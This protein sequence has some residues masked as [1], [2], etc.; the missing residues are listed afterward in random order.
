ML[1]VILLSIALAAGVSAAWLVQAVQPTEAN[2][3]SDT[4]KAAMQTV[5]VLVAATDLPA[6]TVLQADDMRWQ[7]WPAE[8]ANDAFIRYSARPT[9]PTEIAGTTL[10]M[11]LRAG[12]PMMDDQVGDTT[13]GFLSGVLTPG[14]RA[15][16]I[17]VS[18]E[19]TAG[20]FILPNNRVDV[21]LV[22]SCESSADCSNGVEVHTILQNVRVLA[23]DQSGTDPEKSAVV[24]KT[25]TLELSPSDAEE[26]V[27][28]EAAGKL[29]LV[30]RASS[31]ET[32]V[33]LGKDSIPAAQPATPEP[34]RTHTVRVMRAGVAE[35]Y[36]VN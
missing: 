26:I 9:A 33:T 34:A 21:L 7:V 30:L 11:P 16:A 24:G 18:A 6:G 2:A 20:G 28:A 15:V 35:T 19:R 25:A 4:A 1:R 31:D 13:N 32:I 3:D 5:E 12:T 17:P 36:D 22:M 8:A 27:A 29:S 14:M 23:I 10:R